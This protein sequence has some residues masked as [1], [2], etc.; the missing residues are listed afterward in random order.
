MTRTIA[1]A[2]ILLTAAAS[3]SSASESRRTGDMR[4]TSLTAQIDGFASEGG[5]GTTRVQGD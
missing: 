1:A 5:L 4:G 2:L 3:A